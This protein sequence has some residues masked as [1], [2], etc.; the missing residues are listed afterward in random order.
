MIRL[1]EI[2]YA[3]EYADRRTGELEYY[4][5]RMGITTSGW[6]L[7][8]LASGVQVGTVNMLIKMDFEKDL[9]DTT[10]HLEFD[11]I[12]RKK[13]SGG[14]AYIY[15]FNPFKT[16]GSEIVTPR[17]NFSMPPA[18]YISHDSIP[19]HEELADGWI[20]HYGVTDR[21]DL[22]ISLRPNQFSIYCFIFSDGG[23][24]LENKVSPKV[25]RLC[26]NPKISI[27]P[28]TGTK[29]V[30]GGEATISYNL[31]TGCN[32]FL[33]I[34][35]REYPNYNA[36]S[37]QFTGDDTT[38]Y[39]DIQIPGDIFEDSE[40]TDKYVEK[41]FKL[42]STLTTEITFRVYPGAEFA[43][44]I[45]NA[46]M[47]QIQDE[48]TQWATDYIAGFTNVQLTVPEEEIEL[49][50]GATLSSVTAKIQDKTYMLEK[51]NNIYQCQTNVL[52]ATSEYSP[53][54]VT[55]TDSR[56]ATGTY[57]LSL[58]YVM[59]YLPPTLVI[60]EVYRCDA[61]GIKG[62]HEQNYQYYRVRAK[63]T[64]TSLTGNYVQSLECYII[65]D[66]ARHHLTNDV[67]SAAL[68]LKAG[69]MDE[70]RN[71]TLV[72]SAADRIETVTRTFKLDG[73]SRDF[74]VS[75][76]K[77]ATH[78]GIGIT[79]QD[80]SVDNSFE[81]E[82]GSRIIIDDLIISDKE[83][84]LVNGKHYGTTEQRDQLTPQEGQIFFNTNVGLNVAK[85]QI[86]TNGA[87]K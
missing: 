33:S 85:I 10:L 31:S 54:V 46:Q 5:T 7:N 62:A 72:V 58:P 49:K 68:G 66:D 38:H 12:T 74:I 15:T 9:D 8:G 6:T 14:I 20:H 53:I 28:K 87:W 59:E 21:L 32:G 48:R 37:L 75:R 4:W 17:R 81:M 27:K 50:H 51:I 19:K 30:S 84:R 77:G 57:Q 2:S 26:V 60:N 13:T 80:E 52:V 16:D 36:Y 1:K 78:I 22:D 69:I 44:E 67:I 25:T 43:P 18:G 71:Y 40:P 79:P 55:A 86:Y 65:N 83:I 73:I 34:R 47:T 70:K 29:L 11:V 35:W 82:A 3:L 56:G 42:T 64:I 76:K 39:V 63:T 41:D 23:F 24:Y 61:N 45:Q